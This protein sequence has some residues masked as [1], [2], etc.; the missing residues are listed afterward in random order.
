MDFQGYGETAWLSWWSGAPARWGSVYSGGR[1][2][3]YTR[4][5]RRNEQIHLA[6]WNLSL[7]RQCGLRAGEI[8]NE[9]AMP[10]DAL[11]EARKFFARKPFGPGPADLV[12]SAIHQFAA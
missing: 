10:A 3:L 1:E 4:G 2:W 6:D 7:L 5:I 12:S 11:A 8:N 9:F